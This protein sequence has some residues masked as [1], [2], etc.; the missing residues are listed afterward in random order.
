MI[1]DARH[2]EFEPVI[3]PTISIKGDEDWLSVED[4]SKYAAQSRF[5]FMYAVSA[6]NPDVI[7]KVTPIPL[8]IWQMIQ[9]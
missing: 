1:I 5:P 7:A 3:L 2:I 9:V 6:S 8:H 4:F